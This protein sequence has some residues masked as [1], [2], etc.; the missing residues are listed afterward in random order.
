MLHGIERGA[1]AGSQSILAGD[2]HQVIAG[3]LQLRRGHPVDMADGRGEGHERRRHIQILEGAG[4]GILAADGAHAEIDLGHKGAEH[5]RHGLA[6]ALRILAQLLEVLLEGEVH[7]RPLEARGH[8]LRHGIEHGHVGARI[9]VERRQVGVEAP[10]QARHRGG[11]PAQHRQLRHH[12]QSRGQLTGTAEGHEH[13]GGADGGVEALHEALV[14]GV[15]DVA[16]ER[17]QARL[18]GIGRSGSLHNR[19][20]Q[21]SRRLEGAVAG[22]GGTALVVRSG[23]GHGGVLRC[24]VAGQKVAAHVHDGGAAP[25]HA[26]ARLLGHHGHRRGLQVLLVGKRDEGVHILGGQGHGHALLGLGDGELGAIEAVVLLGHGVQVDVQTVGQLPNGHR[27]AAGAEVVAALDHAAG[28]AAAE[29]ALDLALHRRVALLHLGP[30]AFQRFHGMGLGRARGAADAVAARA[31][32]QEH[33]HIT[34]RWRLA[35]HVVG[36]GS[37]HH[38]ADFHALGG[39]AGMVQLVHVPGGQADLVAVGRIAGRRRGHELALGQLPGNGIGHGHRGISRTG[40][41]HGL[42]HVGAAGQGVADGAAHAGSCAAEGLDLGGMVVGLVLEQV[43]PV[44]FHAVHIHLALDGARVNLLGLVEAGEDALLLQPLRADGAH[45]HEAH[46]LLVAAQLVAQLQIAVEGSLHVGVGDGH[47]VEHGAEG[48][49][50]AVIRPVGVDHLDLGDGRVAPLFGKVG[51]A[52]LDVGQVHGQ[53]AISDEGGQLVVGKLGEAVDDL[54]VGRALEGHGQ[55]VAGIQRGL[56]GLHRVDDIALH[57]FHGGLVQ[58]AL[59]VVH[60]RRAHQRALPLADE[61]D[62]LTRGIGALVELAGQKFHGEHRGPVGFGQLEGGNVGL[63]LGEHRGHASSEQLLADA[64]HVVAVY[65]AHGREPLDAHDV[66]QLGGQRAGLAVEPGLLL[67]I[68]ARYH[69]CASL[70]SLQ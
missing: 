54:H 58:I 70:F 53:A 35:A 7:V 33:H 55:G 25:V 15:V 49:V 41:A 65:Q 64:L 3:G 8:E 27:H 26:H 62:A 59:Q 28:I 47:L 45:V 13:R 40:D 48:G 21:A 37:T 22:G 24:A 20:G 29:Q 61:L 66:A 63:R 38:G 17:R 44:L 5:G 42:V 11:G 43:Q 31:T 60:H 10:G 56:A 23:H 52:E 50:A 1:Q 12:G 67:N 14:A 34:G 6:P 30:A 4:H 36:W 68:D 16:H 46:G 69:G 19:I 39:V 57:G 18:Q 32:A 51:A 2:P 9:G